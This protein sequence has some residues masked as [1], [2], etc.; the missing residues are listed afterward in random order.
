MK[1]LTQDFLYLRDELQSHD[2]EYHL[3]QNY[4]QQ[5]LQA[6]VQCHNLEEQKEEQQIAFLHYDFSLCRVQEESS[7]ASLQCSQ[8][9]QQLLL[10]KDVYSEMFKYQQK[11][12]C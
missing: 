1:I 2:K 8:Q 3:C 7:H 5:Q 11:D 10:I 6:S 4:Q 9:N 12:E